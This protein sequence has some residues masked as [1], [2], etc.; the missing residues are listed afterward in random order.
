MWAP[1]IDTIMTL[2]FFLN[3]M[4]KNGS[5]GIILIV[6]LIVVLLCVIVGFFLYCYGCCQCRRRTRNENVNENVT[7]LIELILSE[8]AENVIKLENRNRRRE[9][10]EITIDEPIYEEA[11][12]QEYIQHHNTSKQ[13][14]S[15]KI[16]KTQPKDKTKNQPKPDKHLN[17]SKLENIYG[18]SLAYFM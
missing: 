9:Q 5:T 17:Q 12:E 2:F 14:V 10:Q 13:S 3:L 15:T 16:Y 6:G 8:K 7:Q 4:F 18:S 1:Q 11:I